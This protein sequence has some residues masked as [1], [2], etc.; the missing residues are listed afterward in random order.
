MLSAYLPGLVQEAISSAY[1]SD[2]LLF[3][4]IQESYSARGALI[5]LVWKPVPA[6]VPGQLGGQQLET[7]YCIYWWAKDRK[8][9]N[10]PSR[11]CRSA[12][13]LALFLEKKKQSD[14]GA[15]SASVIPGPAAYGGKPSPAASIPFDSAASEIPVSSSDDAGKAEDSLVL[16]ISSLALEL[17]HC[18][19]VEFEV[20]D[21]S[22]GL[23]YTS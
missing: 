3:W 13:R 20:S 10:P 12:Q 15:S 2:R 7:Y 18:Q 21:D 6:D 1:P 14:S 4:K 11:Q 8:R 22:P 23:R 19:K 5:Q 9:R 17:L 16:A